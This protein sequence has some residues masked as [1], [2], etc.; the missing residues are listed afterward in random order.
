MA[1]SAI[2]KLWLKRNTQTFDLNDAGTTASSDYKL[3]IQNYSIKRSDLIRLNP[4]R[5]DQKLIY[6]KAIEIR[7]FVSN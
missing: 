6:K 3:K 2:F 1:T 5:K 4:K 7:L